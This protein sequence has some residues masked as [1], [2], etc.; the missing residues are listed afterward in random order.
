MLKILH[1]RLPLT[2]TQVLNVIS[3][4]LQSFV[5]FNVQH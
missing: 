4:K 3:S 1:Y 2:S 5:L